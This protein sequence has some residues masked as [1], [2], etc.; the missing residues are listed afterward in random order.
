MTSSPA[1]LDIARRKGL[2]HCPDQAY[3]D[4]FSDKWNRICRALG[5]ARQQSD[6]ALAELLA[7]VA[8]WGG[9]L[10]GERCAYPS[11]LSADGFPAE[12]SVSWR[13]GV[14]EVRILLE[15]LGAE[16]TPLASQEAGRALTRRLATRRGV[17]IERYLA[18]EDLFV[19]ADPQPY[20]P[21]VW[22]SLAWRPGSRP[23]Y[24]VYLNPQ[25]GGLGTEGEAVAEAMARLGMARAWRPVAERYP[26]LL[27]RGHRI[28]FL[29]LDL[30]PDETARVKVYFRHAPMPLSEM[31]AV[32]AFA[33]RHDPDRAH[34][35]VRAVY[36]DVPMAANEPMTCLA[37]RGH[38]PQAEEANLY[39]R[40]PGAARDDAE[41]AGRV[42]AV[43]AAEG[44]DPARHAA[45]LAAVA[46]APPETTIGLQELL[47]YRTTGGSAAADV[48]VYFRFNVYDR[49]VCAADLD[50]ASR[51][52]TP[53][54]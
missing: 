31:G 24:K 9:R 40:L 51:R 13:G 17:A 15:S 29:A 8:P 53:A 50:A 10:I 38:A 20:R 22:H 46:P 14:P 28:E 25:V 1:I 42:A 44:V 54:A 35:A 7:M 26:G 52:S 47:S 49:P 16:P 39:L 18:V 36:P 21:T 30:T 27:A 34:R 48:G 45:V 11:F 4:F 5:I 33:L 23:G 19:S 32:A 41:A 3:G 37:F 2:F 12:F 6:G 43:L